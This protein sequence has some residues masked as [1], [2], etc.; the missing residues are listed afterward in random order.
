[1]EITKNS[2]RNMKLSFSNGYTVSVTMKND[3]AIL[4]WIA[5]WITDGGKTISVNEW[6]HDDHVAAFIRRIKSLQLPEKNSLEQMANI[7]KSI[8]RDFG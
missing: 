5:Y 3:S 1:M 8:M 6:V 7:E 4:S 2:T